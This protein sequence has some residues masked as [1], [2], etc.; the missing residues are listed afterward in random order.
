MKRLLLHWSSFPVTSRMVAAYTGSPSKAL[1]TKVILL[2]IVGVA[3]MIG[4]SID[5]EAQ[6]DS[7]R[8]LT[9]STVLKND[10]LAVRSGKNLTAGA[11]TESIE[12]RQSPAFNI[13]NV[14][15]STIDRSTDTSRH[16]LGKNDPNQ[17]VRISIV[18]PQTFGVDHHHSWR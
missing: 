5:M 2:L 4:V 7:M 18:V 9:G 13:E 11:D 8:F 6:R 3:T 10:K 15:N 12:T 1:V 16:I 17:V 14:G